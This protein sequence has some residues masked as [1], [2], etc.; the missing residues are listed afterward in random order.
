VNEQPKIPEWLKAL[1]RGFE[2]PVNERTKF[3]RRIAKGGWPPDWFATA[4]TDEAPWVFYLTDIFIDHCLKKTDQIIER[5]GAYVNEGL[6]RQNQTL[7][8]DK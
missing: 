2:W 8:K 5:L 1:G 4:K 6:I 3:E 7:K